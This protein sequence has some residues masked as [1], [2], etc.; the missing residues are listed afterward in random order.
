MTIRAPLA[1]CLSLFALG[2]LRATEAMP[3]SKT[4]SRGEKVC[5]SLSLAAL[6][7]KSPLLVIGVGGAH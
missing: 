5:N 1:L 7:G 6:V 3:Q 4:F 2:E